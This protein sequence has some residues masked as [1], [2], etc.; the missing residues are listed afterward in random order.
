MPQK[1]HALPIGTVTPPQCF[2]RQGAFRAE[3]E[4]PGDE[5]TVEIDVRTG[6]KRWRQGGDGTAARKVGH[7]APDRHGADEFRSF[8]ST[9]PYVGCGG[10]KADHRK[11][12]KTEQGG[13]ARLG[14]QTSQRDG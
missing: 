3:E 1:L 11:G 7:R 9:P 14:P 10:R 4:R 2:P 5:A 8:V 12:A 13:P 6:D